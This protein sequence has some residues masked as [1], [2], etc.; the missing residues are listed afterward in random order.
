MNAISCAVTASSS[1]SEIEVL[2]T[3]LA[4]N[5]RVTVSLS[6]V[7]GTGANFSASLGFSKGDNDS[8]RSVTAAD[9]LRA[10]GRAG[11]TADITNFLYDTDFGGAVSQSDVD[12]VKANAGIQF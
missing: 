12:A 3:T 5:T 8:T 11:Q 1:G 7:N 4:D 6:D 9:I 10:K 2:I